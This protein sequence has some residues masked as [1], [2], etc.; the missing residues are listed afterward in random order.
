MGAGFPASASES[1]SPFEAAKAS[2]FASQQRQRAGMG[3]GMAEGMGGGAGGG[4]PR[5]SSVDGSGRAIESPRSAARRGLQ[6]G[7]GSDNRGMEVRGEARSPILL[8]AR[9]RHRLSAGSDSV[10]S[11]ASLHCGFPPW[12]AGGR[13]GTSRGGSFPVSLP[14]HALYASG[15]DPVFDA[16][17]PRLLTPKGFSTGFG[18]AAGPGP[19]G[20]G[21]LGSAAPGSG[22]AAVAGRQLAGQHRR[23][24]SFADQSWAAGGGGMGGG[25]IESPRRMGSGGGG[26]ILPPR[27]PLTMGGGGS[28]TWGDNLNIGEFTPSAV[29]SPKPPRS[30]YHNEFSQ[31]R[32]AAAAAAAAGNASAATGAGQL[33]LTPGRNRALVAAR[34]GGGGGGALMRGSARERPSPGID[35]DDDVW[36]AAAAV[37][38]VAG[39]GAG[40]AGGAGG[41]AGGAFELRKAGSSSRLEQALLPDHRV[42][43]SLAFPFPRLHSARDPHASP[44]RPPPPSP[45]PALLAGRSAGGTRGPGGGV[46]GEARRG[47]G[48]VQGWVRGGGE[49]D[50]GGGVRRAGS[51][52]G[53]GGGGPGEGDGMREGGGGG[54]GEGMR[55]GGGGGVGEG[56]RVERRNTV[57][58]HAEQFLKSLSQYISRGLT[59]E[60]GT[61]AGEGEGEKGDA[62]ANMWQMMSSGSMRWRDFILRMPY[63]D[64]KKF[65]SVS[66]TKIGS[67]RYGVIRTCLSRKTRVVLA[68]KTIRKDQ[69]KC[70]EDAE[71]VRTEV[72]ILGMLRNHPGIISLHDAFEDAKYVHLIME[73]CRG[74]DLFDRVKLRG[75][76][77]ETDAAIVC[78][79]LVEALLH[80][81]SNGV[82]HRDVKPENVLMCDKDVDTKIKLIDFGVATFYKRGVPCTERAG[83]VEYTAPEVLDKSYGPECDIWSA[84]VVLYILLCGFPPFWAATNA[85][86]EQSVRAAAVD[87]RHPRWAAVSDGAKDLVKRMLTKDVRRRISALEIFAHPWIRAAEKQ[88]RLDS[89]P[90]A[91]NGDPPS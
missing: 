46:A 80:C 21:L 35:E 79:S 34:G 37:A 13:G 73:M 62:E 10:D 67:G 11:G 74:G 18:A 59:G 50:K 20:S 28:G 25:A 15:A 40:G 41:R 63:D 48:R 5:H 33:P 17:S 72:I 68:C 19:A 4:I 49:W 75:Q 24:H 56:M 90:Q 81:H 82:I 55:E 85:E 76:F 12:G 70:M 6:Y 1:L 78:R 45:P 64:V 9:A 47:A 60:L 44:P 65:Y 58:P 71:D 57:D 16:M 83:T 36:G 66:A 26:S 91:P 29:Q 61:Y 14:P 69:V 22:A 84:G 23:H 77:K 43:G 88:Q 31:D 86:L 30:P 53:V 51:V 8:G 89:K 32:A 42:Q 3:G 27:S 52:G 2:L 54:V 39:G 7:F 87:F 38:G